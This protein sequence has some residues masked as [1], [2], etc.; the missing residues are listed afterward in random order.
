MPDWLGYLL[1]LG[2]VVVLAPFIAWFGRR[3]GRNVKGGL[4]IAMLGVGAIVDPPRK[5]L[6]EAQEGEENAPEPS[7]EP[8]DP[9]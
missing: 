2:A 8:K 5:H 9:A 3:H 7:G 4:A 1:A 6:I